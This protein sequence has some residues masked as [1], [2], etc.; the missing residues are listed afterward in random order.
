[1]S[2]AA[3]VKPWEEEGSP[4]KTESQFLIWVRGVLRSGWSKHPLKLEYIKRHRKRIL[5]P[6]KNARFPEVWGMTCSVCMQDKVQAEIEIDHISET[7]GTFRKLEDAYEYMKHLFMVNFAK[8]QPVCKPCHKIIS[9]SQR[10]GVSF[11]EAALQK[12]VIEIMKKPKMELLEFCQKYG[13]SASMLTNAEKRKTAV[14][15]I[16]KENIIDTTE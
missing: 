11:E 12:K 15:R 16:L 5:N 8:M 14:T 3:D 13:Y 10:M 2:L 7:G 6:K 4:W 9:H 1:M